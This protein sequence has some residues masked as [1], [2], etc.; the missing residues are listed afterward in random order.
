MFL[1]YFY[2]LEELH[3]V[4]KLKSEVNWVELEFVELWQSNKS[5]GNFSMTPALSC[6]RRFHETGLAGVHD[7]ADV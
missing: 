4:D 5:L 6:A 3:E 7:S 2:Q 1:G